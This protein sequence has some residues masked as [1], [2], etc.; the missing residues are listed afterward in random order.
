MDWYL[1][2]AIIAAGFITLSRFRRRA[3]GVRFAVARKSN[4]EQFVVEAENEGR[5]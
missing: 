3:V 5:R 2:L 4:G 1:Y